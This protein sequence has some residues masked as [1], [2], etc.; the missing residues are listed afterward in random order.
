MPREQGWNQAEII[1]NFP[2]S[3]KENHQKKLLGTCTALCS[4]LFP[5]VEILADYY[6]TYFEHSMM[7]FFTADRF[8]TVISNNN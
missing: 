1:A 6:K 3:V 7:E 2:P 4:G 8:S 5:A